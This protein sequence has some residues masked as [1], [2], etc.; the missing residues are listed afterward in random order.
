MLVVMIRA[1]IKPG[2]NVSVSESNGRLKA[3][4]SAETLRGSVLRA[5]T[6]VVREPYC[7][8]DLPDAITLNLDKTG[9]R[10]P[11]ECLRYQSN[12]AV[13]P[14]ASISVNC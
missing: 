11:G 8:S 2:T 9:T 10:T 1:M 12:H 14:R 4:H 5:Q 6:D 13:S 7:L 3:V